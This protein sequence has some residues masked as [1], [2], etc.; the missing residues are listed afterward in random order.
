MRVRPDAGMEVVARTSGHAAGGDAPSRL[1]SEPDDRDL[2]LV[3][4][5][6]SHAGPHRAVARCACGHTRVGHNELALDRER[7]GCQASSCECQR[8]APG[9]A[10]GRDRCA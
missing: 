8:Y 1:M 3:C 7:I 10:R 9:A 4:W 2:C 5:A 6:P